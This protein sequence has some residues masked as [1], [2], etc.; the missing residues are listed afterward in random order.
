VPLRRRAETLFAAAG[1]ACI[2]SQVLLIVLTRGLDHDSAASFWAVLPL[3][4]GLAVPTGLLLVAA[5]WLVR[6]KPSALVLATLIT[7]GLA[8]RLAWLG[9]PPPLEDDYHRY[10]LDGAVV[11]HGLDPYAHPPKAFLSP[12][13]VPEAYQRVATGAEATLRAINFPE[14]RSIY[15]G[16][17]QA[18]FALAHV[19]APFSFDGLR[20]VFL[21]GE[22]A[23]FLL[24][25]TLLRGLGQ[26]PAWALIY[27]WN[28]FVAYV[29]IG[30]AHV[31]ALI[32]PFVL[33]AVLAMS[34]DR[35]ATALA[36]LALG[37]GVKIWPLLLAPMVLWPL[38]RE[39]RRLL[40]AGSVLAAVLALAVGPVIL[41]ALR[42]DSGLSAYAG[43][44]SNNNGFYT[45]IR[46]GLYLV[47][48][49]WPAADQALRPALAL[50]TGV[51]ALVVATRGDRTLPSLSER[52]LIV[53]AAVFY[54]S[55]AQFPWYAVWFLPL[56]VVCRSWPLLLSSALLPFY[57]LFFP[58]W[59]IWTGMWFFY[60][61]AFIHSLPVLGWLA[62]G[63][64]Q[65]RGRQRAVT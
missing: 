61:A 11:A 1:L 50:A 51:T 57:Y 6:V 29:L 2:A 12:G 54:L 8:M 60:A 43:S 35:P 23:T 63:W 32:P 55:P 24:L 3:I 64:I 53:A 5:P 10:L 58:L 37:A 39:P 52:T 9:T 49:T 17:A 27:W 40:A 42:P 56:A 19:I 21:G 25:L 46:H 31:D 41:S 4:L 47:L 20:I 14:M 13:A 38:L 28:P 33:G 18:A 34:R 45:W 59:P 22:I 48:G 36:L 30:I 7:V 15:P 16:V 44:W 62:Y 26:S 65:A